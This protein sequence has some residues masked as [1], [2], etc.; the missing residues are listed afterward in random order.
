[1]KEWKTKIPINIAHGG[2]AAYPVNGHLYGGIL[3]LKTL[4]G[5]GVKLHGAGM[6]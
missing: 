3:L 6:F 5:A 1:M 4:T 2:R